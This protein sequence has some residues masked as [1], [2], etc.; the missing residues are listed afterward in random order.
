[1]VTGSPAAALPGV[2]D[3]HTVLASCP[4]IPAM[5]ALPL[6]Y[7]AFVAVQQPHYTLQYSEI[8]DIT[9]RTTQTRGRLGDLRFYEWADATGYW[10]FDNAS[11]C[12]QFAGADIGTE[13]PSV[14]LVA[15]F[16][17][18][19][20]MSFVG[21]AR[22]QG[23][24]CNT[25]A[26]VATSASGPTAVAFDVLIFFTAANGSLVRAE[27]R[28]PDGTMTAYEWAA[29]SVAATAPTMLQKPASCAGQALQPLPSIDLGT[30]RGTPRW[31]CALAALALTP[32]FIRT[33]GSRARRRHGAARPPC[34]VLHGCDGRRPRRHRTARL[35]KRRPLAPR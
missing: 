12:S 17:N 14:W 3:P 28:A 11:Q 8:A 27:I 26:G 25:Y 22:A 15:N 34:L 6:S 18:N 35:R 19:S 13:I 23:V 29:L 16:I 24:L 2:F 7:S 21:Q 1:M 20:T 30:V 5:P 31:P 4:T 9:T 32:A 10:R 33:G